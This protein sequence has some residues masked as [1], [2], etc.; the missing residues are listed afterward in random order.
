MRNQRKIINKSNKTK[1]IKMLTTHKISSK[2]YHNSRTRPII[3]P[4]A[5][6]SDSPHDSES[7][8]RPEVGVF[9][10]LF[11]K[12]RTEV[13]RKTPDPK[14]TFKVTSPQMIDWE[15]CSYLKL[16]LHFR[17]K[18]IF[19]PISFLTIKELFVEK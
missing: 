19:P 2:A 9:N 6:V 17:L 10:R 18:L 4:P 12:K 5:G 7:P 13:R 11:P 14:L 1:Q 8:H 15:Y 16:F 3:V